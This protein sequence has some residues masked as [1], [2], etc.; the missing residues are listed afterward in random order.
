[1]RAEG[2]EL[3]VDVVH[4]ERFGGPVAVEVADGEAAAPAEKVTPSP[5]A[6]GSVSLPQLQAMPCS[7]RRA[8]SSTPSASRSAARRSRTPPFMANAMSVGA[9]RI[10]SRTMWLAIVSCASSARSN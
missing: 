9:G 5:R 10:T 4:G 2:A 8:R 1:M 7:V 3:A 6:S